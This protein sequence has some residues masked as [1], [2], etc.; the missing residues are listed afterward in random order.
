MR[1]TPCQSCKYHIKSGEA[2]HWWCNGCGE[3]M[4]VN[5]KAVRPAKSLV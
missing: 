5:G 1:K 2:A 4:L 3:W